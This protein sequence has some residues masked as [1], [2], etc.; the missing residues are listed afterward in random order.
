MT[1][2]ITSRCGMIT[3]AWEMYLV[4]DIHQSG[5]VLSL[6]RVI[7][8]SMDNIVSNWCMISDWMQGSRACRIRMLV[9]SDMLRV[10][11]GEHT[12]VRATVTCREWSWVGAYHGC[13]MKGAASGN[14]ISPRAN[15]GRIRRAGSRASGAGGILTISRS[16]AGKPAGGRATPSALRA[17]CIAVYWIELPHSS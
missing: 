7:M 17:S 3:N 2:P 6:Q 15:I 10:R 1:P 12:C 4:R 8:S 14:A 11:A 13:E 16:G 9:T 5:T